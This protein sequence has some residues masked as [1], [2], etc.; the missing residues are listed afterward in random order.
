MNNKMIKG[1]VAGATGIVLLM[2]GFGTYALWSDSEN[3]AQNSVSSGDLTV[4][5]SAGWYDDSN[6]GSGTP[7]AP[8]WSAGD[9]MVPGDTI[10]YNQVFAVTGNGKNLEGTIELAELA[11]DEDTDFGTLVRS[12]NVEVSDP[13]TATIVKEDQDSFT[14]SAPFGAAE[15]TATVTYTF[16]AGTAA[17]GTTD[18]DA[19]FVTPAAAFTITQTPAS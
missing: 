3:L 1:S 6:D 7:E 10:T 2:G 13:G 9:E 16:P 17:L 14:F 11:D 4:N 8:D 15:L 12:V 18:Q 19:S 5:T